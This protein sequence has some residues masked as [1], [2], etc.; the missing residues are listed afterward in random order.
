[1]VKDQ[2]FQIK[3]GKVMI[4]QGSDK[5]PIDKHTYYKSLLTGDGR[6]YEKYVN[7]STY[8]RKKKTASWREFSKLTSKIKHEG[9]DPR[10]SPVQI[11]FRKNEKPY[12]SHGRHR[13]A[14]LRYIHGP[15]STLVVYK[16]EK[17]QTGKVMKVK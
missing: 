11:S 13:I 5:F 1:M 9:Y 15:K 10:K 8:Q 16:K 2:V 3:M 7:K 12:V 6:L 14:I 17:E 4:R